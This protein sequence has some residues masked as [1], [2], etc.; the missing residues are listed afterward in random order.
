MVKQKT[1]YRFVVVFIS[2]LIFSLFAA[3]PSQADQPTAETKGI[4]SVIEGMRVRQLGGD[5]ILLEIRGY[6]MP[7]PKAVDDSD[8]AMV[9]Q[10]TGVRFPVNTDKQDWWDEYGWSV[11]KFTKKMSDEWWK[12]YDF[13]LAQRIQVVSADN[14]GIKMTITGEK[15]LKIESIRCIVRRKLLKGL[16]LL[17]LNSCLSLI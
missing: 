8:S 3:L 1:S 4:K 13:P 15:P 2:L 17:E 11:F 9:L 16:K 5:Q 12:K 14:D 7:L 6:K 10:W